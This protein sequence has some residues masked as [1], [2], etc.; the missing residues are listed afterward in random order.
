MLTEEN[1]WERIGRLWEKTGR[2]KRRLVELHKKVPSCSV[3]NGES[4]RDKTVA[5]TIR[6]DMSH[7]WRFDF[8][9]RRESRESRTFPVERHYAYYVLLNKKKGSTFF[10]AFKTCVFRS[11]RDDETTTAYPA[12]RPNV[13]RRLRRTNATKNSDR[14]TVMKTTSRSSRSNGTKGSP[15]RSTFSFVF[16]R[17]RCLRLGVR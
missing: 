12:R 3:R 13:T 7:A 14:T 6:F 5:K 9:E 4:L 2:S 8:G 10:V 15:I 17:F 16:S 1:K 11:K